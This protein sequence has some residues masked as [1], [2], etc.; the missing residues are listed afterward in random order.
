MLPRL[1]PQ[2][3]SQQSQLSWNIHLLQVFFQVTSIPKKNNVPS[4]YPFPDPSMIP[5]RDSGVF[6]SDHPNIILTIYFY[7]DTS[8]LPNLK[9][10]L[11]PSLLEYTYESGI[12]EDS[13]EKEKYKPQFRKLCST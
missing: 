11:V 4:A 1:S 8:M 5:S 9:P 3:L 13:L 10:T 6:L 12:P 2:F 7:R